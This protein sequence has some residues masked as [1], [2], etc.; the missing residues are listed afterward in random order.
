M[1][2]PRSTSGRS[3]GSEPGNG[4]SNPSLGA[5]SRSGE[6][7]VTPEPLRAPVTRHVRAVWNRVRAGRTSAAELPG[8]AQG[9]G[10]D[11]PF[12]PSSP[13]APA[14]VGWLRGLRRAL[15]KRLGVTRPAGSNPAPT[16]NIDHPSGWGGDG[17]ALSMAVL[18]REGRGWWHEHEWREAAERLAHYV[19][20]RYAE[21]AGYPRRVGPRPFPTNSTAPV[22]WKR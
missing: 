13:L 15:A 4:G 1:N 14:K 9:R 11:R 10:E 5:G 16:V 21:D 19:Q 7:P 18:H 12:T 3:P 8:S 22:T 2:D 20:N 6:G 17:L